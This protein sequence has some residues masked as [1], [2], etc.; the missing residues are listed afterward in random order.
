MLSPGGFH[1]RGFQPLPE[2]L[3]GKKKKKKIKTN[4]RLCRLCH[5]VARVSSSPEEGQK[6][7]RGSGMQGL[8]VGGEQDRTQSKANLAAGPCP[9]PL[10]AWVSRASRR[11][12]RAWGPR[13]LRIPCWQAL[14]A[15]WD[16]LPG[17]ENIR[18]QVLCLHPSLKG[19]SSRRPAPKPAAAR[20]LG[21]NT[22]PG[23]LP[24]C[25]RSRR[26]RTVEPEE[27]PS[28]PRQAPIPS[29][30]RVV[31]DA[32]RCSPAT[33]HVPWKRWPRYR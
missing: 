2:P 9:R 25:F 21:T 16:S 8:G 27:A 14:G 17:P 18:E 30:P 22:V 3:G 13:G 32:A 28:R 1:P 4:P 15:A 20:R 31:R 33:W 10:G 24:P 12:R 11:R 7:S 6:P 26:A 23:P 19:T 29:R 5:G